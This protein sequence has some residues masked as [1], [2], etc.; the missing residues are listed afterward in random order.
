MCRYYKLYK[1]NKYE[2]AKL[3]Q[4]KDT[5]NYCMNLDIKEYWEASH[6]ILRYIV[7]VSNSAN[8]IKKK[9]RKSTKLYITLCKVFGIQYIYSK[10]LT[11]KGAIKNAIVND[12]LEYIAHH[13]SYNNTIVE[14]E[15]DCI[16]SMRI[17][18][19][20]DIFY[21]EECE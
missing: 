7:S 15:I 13:I 6:D 18:G 11:T 5:V 1:L 14:S 4:I 3:M 8:F 10:N 21:A 2:Y 17:L 19:K 12:I 9:R 16:I 20:S